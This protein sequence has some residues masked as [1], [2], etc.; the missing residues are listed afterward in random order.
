MNRVFL[1]LRG[2]LEPQRKGCYALQSTPDSVA[3]HQPNA[4][5][6]LFII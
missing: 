1:A 2:S 6:A 3:S 5:G 4:A